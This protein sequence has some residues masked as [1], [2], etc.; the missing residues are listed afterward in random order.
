[1]FKKKWSLI[2]RWFLPVS[3]LMSV[4]LA[5]IPVCFIS[6]STLAASPPAILWAKTYGGS[7]FDDFNCVQQ[8]ADGGYIGAGVTASSGAGMKDGFL[9]KTDAS[10]N[11]QWQQTFGGPADDGFNSVQQTA[12]GGYIVAGYTMDETIADLGWLVKTDAAGTKQWEQIMYSGNH[13]DEA[14]CVQQTADGGYIVAGWGAVL[15]HSY[16]GWLWKTDASGNETGLHYYGGLSADQLFSV[17]QTA[18]GGYIAAG[19][20]ASY[21]TTPTQAWLIKTDSGLTEQWHQI[22]MK[23][24]NGAFY[25]ARQAADGGYIAAGCSY[26][27]H[28]AWL[29]KTDSGGTKQWDLTYGGP[30]TLN[31]GTSVQQTADGGYVMAGRIVWAGYSQ[32]WLVKADASGNQQWNLALFASPPSLEGM[33]GAYSVQ[34]TFD[35]GY[36]VAGFTDSD[37]P[38]G[39]GVDY[40]DAWLV[41]IAGEGPVAPVPEPAPLILLGTGL[42]LLGGLVVLGKRGAAETRR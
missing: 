34:Q 25:S 5:M 8:T 16:D 21:E 41:K 32:G 29:V 2:P 23:D 14:Q 35:G 24:D 1:M 6:H 33:L 19:M 36:I 28:E 20:T 37:N 40:D 11:V 30:P 31:W 22:F 10:G 3:L 38:N 18:D 13:Q 9:V 4:L 39:P 12:D 7:K 17:Q 15:G 27:Q 42:L 26:N